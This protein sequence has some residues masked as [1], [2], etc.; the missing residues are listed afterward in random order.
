MKLRGLIIAIFA[1]CALNAAAADFFDKSLPEEVFTLGMRAGV[2]T[3]NRTI[4]ADVFSDWNYNYWGTGID[5][6]AVADI[7]FRD[8]IS[9][10]PGF[11]FQ[12]RHGD[13][14]YITQVESVVDGVQQ[15]DPL[16]QVGHSSRYTVNVP[17]LCRIHFNVTDE[18]R[19]SVDAGPYFS[20]IVGKHDSNVKY[21][22][23]TIADG[24]THIV[25]RTFDFGIKFG[26]GLTLNRHY[27]FGI[28]YMAGC[29]DAWRQHSLGG[30]NKAWTFCLGYD[31]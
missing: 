31:F 2:N 18:L 11:F 23:G 25:G 6:G 19:W 13:H 14:A 9:L 24:A 26:T 30:R 17:I 12:S 5:L 22:T 16:T 3:T 4:G 15:L 29:L 1:V 20:W 7:R 10:Q 8:Y 28:H 27:Y 21:Y